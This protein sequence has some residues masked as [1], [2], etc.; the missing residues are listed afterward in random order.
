VTLVKL[1]ISHNKD[2]KTLPQFL[3]DIK[4]LKEINITG[5]N[6][7][8]EGLKLIKDLEQKGVIVKK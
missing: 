5:L 8:E 4:Y 7:D 1:D 3:K 6:L 2:L